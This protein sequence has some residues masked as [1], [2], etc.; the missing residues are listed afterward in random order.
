MKIDNFPKNILNALLPQ[1]SCSTLRR[2]REQVDPTRLI[3]QQ[4]KLT[5]WNQREFHEN[6]LHA[7]S[8]LRSGAKEIS[9]K[10][11]VGLLEAWG[12]KGM[13]AEL[14]YL[15]EISTQASLLDRGMILECG[16]G[17]ST[18]ILALYVENNLSL[19]MCTL[20]HK[21][22]WKERVVEAIR[23]LGTKLN[24]RILS[25]DLTKHSGYDWYD[26][27]EVPKEI[28]SLVVCDGPPGET[29]GGRYGLIPEIVE[30][31]TKDTKIILDDAQRQGEHAVLKKWQ[32]EF[33]IKFDIKGTEKKFAII[34]INPKVYQHP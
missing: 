20:E 26:T 30:Y 2:F 11:L 34:S 14:D 4:I 10:N 16:S 13:A 15:K 23:P 9:E 25:S 31:C 21:A 32:E 7:Q 5:S 27:K 22:K 3:K 8:E 19:S 1:E 28:I 6:L 24:I 18:A 17:V 12:N 33:S 29:R